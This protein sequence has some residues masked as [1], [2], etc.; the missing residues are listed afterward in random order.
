MWQPQ[1]YNLV[2]SIIFSHTTTTPN[3]CFKGPSENTEIEILN[4]ILHSQLIHLEHSFIVEILPII[5][6]KTVETMLFYFRFVLAI[7]RQE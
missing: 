3:I 1:N 2:Y 7:I 5:S 6:W 4:N